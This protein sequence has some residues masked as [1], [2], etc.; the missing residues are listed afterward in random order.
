MIKAE[1]GSFGRK[2]TI[3]II[4]GFS[5]SDICEFIVDEIFI[6]VENSKILFPK[7]VDT[8]MTKNKQ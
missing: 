3:K 1:I 7:I 2:F 6:D 4:E 8:I 5:D